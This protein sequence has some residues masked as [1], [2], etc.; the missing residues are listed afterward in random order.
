LKHIDTLVS[1]IYKVLETQNEITEEDINYLST[2]LASKLSGR[3][4]EDKSRTPTLRMSNVGTPC[5]RKLWYHVNASGEGE[6]LPGHTLLK[7]MYGEILECLILWLAKKAGHTVE[8]EQTEVNVA[9]IKGHRDAIIDGRLID[10]KSATTA[11]MRKFR[12]NKLRSDDPFGYIDQLE[13][14]FHASDDVEDKDWISFLAVDKQLGNIVLDTYS[15]DTTKDQFEKKLTDLQETV[16]QEEPP[17]RGFK[18]IAEG[19]SG[20]RKLCVNCS[21][22]EHKHHCWSGL[23][24]FL[25]S[26]GPTFL[27]KV[28]KEP[29]VMESTSDKF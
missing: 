17:K 16:K 9:G 12:E 29:K 18:D 7:F 1:D 19:A 14:Y 10:V 11:S 2:M 28:V 26:S 22:C 8:G 3:L 27:T 25:Y 20:N 23:R 6:K 21:Y 13:G 15:V 5:K 24:R 4:G